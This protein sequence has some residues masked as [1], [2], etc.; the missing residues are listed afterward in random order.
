MYGRRPSGLPHRDGSGRDS[1]A[2]QV[3]GLAACQANLRPRTPEGWSES[4]VPWSEVPVQ[5]RRS[6]DLCHDLRLFHVGGFAPGPSRSMV[7][8]SG[9]PPIL[10]TAKAGRP[11]GRTA[12][13]RGREK[14]AQVLA[15][16]PP[17]S[18]AQDRWP[19]AEA[20]PRPPIAL[21]PPSAP[22]LVPGVF[23]S[24][25]GRFRRW[26]STRPGRTPTLPGPARRPP[27]AFP[28]PGLP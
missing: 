9:T 1:D 4:V 14:W 6:C 21:F 24:A 19:P 17:P 13:P 16:P 11:W 28:F 15:G 25:P 3:R 20:S 8:L 10:V 2:G 7:V 12:S 23:S 5:R 18:H 22:G 27:R 26:P